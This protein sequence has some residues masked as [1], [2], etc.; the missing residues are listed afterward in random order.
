MSK[1]FVTDE[2]K[3]TR[4]PFLR[5]MLIKSLQ[6]SGLEFEDAYKLAGEIR[7]DFDDVDSVTLQE[8]RDRIAEILSVD[9]PDIILRRYRK[10]AI[11]SESIE[12]VME[13]GHTEPFSRGVF[14]TRLLNCGID[15]SVCNKITR[16]IHDQLLKTRTTRLSVDNLIAITYKITA[17]QAEKK[18]ADHY[19]M[20]CAFNRSNLPL[21]ILIGGVP[22]SGKSTIATEL[23]NR[24]SI[25]RTQSTDMLREVMRALI[26]KRISPA[27]HSSS[28]TAGKAMHAAAFYK[29]NL[30]DAMISGFNTQSDMVSVA[31]DAVLSR[32][33]NEQVS[34]ILEGVHIRPRLIKKYS[35]T[36]AIVVPVMLAVLDQSRLKRNYTGRSSQAEKRAAQ[37]Y[38]DSFDAIW[39]LQETILSEADAADIEIVDNISRD[40][41][42]TEI[43]KV[44]T[45]TIAATYKGKLKQLRTE[46]KV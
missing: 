11:Y 8:L 14:V 33:M 9:Y 45:E 1:L 34:V 30:A 12:I 2:K 32:A 46:F 19:L 42:V 20:W 40:E 36:Q 37:R 25:I 15:V 38:L 27:L 4:I 7:E 41:T 16:L 3:E 10:Q 35:K 26:P 18:A 22:G 39:Q 23:A 21:M 28:F 29:D 24:L 17:K 6:R 5:G 43:C 31:G 44:V 13:D